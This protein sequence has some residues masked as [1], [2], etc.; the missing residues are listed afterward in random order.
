MISE[1]VKGPDTSR[2]FVFQTA[3]KKYWNEQLKWTAPPIAT[4]AQIV[5]SATLTWTAK[6]CE[7]NENN[8]IDAIEII[9]IRLKRR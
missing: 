7:T 1:R 2:C 6:Y 8:N 3:T 4:D 5:R 9:Y